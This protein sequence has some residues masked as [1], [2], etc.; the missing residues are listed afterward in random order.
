MIDGKVL[1]PMIKFLRPRLLLAIGE[2]LM[3]VSLIHRPEAG[4]PYNVWGIH[5]SQ[6][7]IA[8]FMAGAVLSLISYKAKDFDWR[9]VLYVLATLPFLGYTLTTLYLF[10]F[11]RKLSSPTVSLTVVVIY[12]GL[13]M[14]LLLHFVLVA[15]LELCQ[16]HGVKPDD[17]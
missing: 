2:V 10:I 12:F 7:F 1:K 16:K 4:S 3:T 6:F 14:L 5:G 11:I 9:I 15:Q 13:Y 17:D 8:F